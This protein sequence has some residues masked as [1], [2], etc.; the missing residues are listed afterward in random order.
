MKKVMLLLANGFEMYEAAV[1][2]DVFGWNNDEIAEDKVELITVGLRDRIKCTW[3]FTVIPEKLI[4]EVNIDE[5]DALAI[6]G[7]FEEAGFYEDAYSK[8]FL[9][10]IKDFNDQGKIISSVCVAALPVAKSGALNGRKGITF[11]LNEGYR[12][13]QLQ[14]FGVELSDTLFT[15]DDNIVTCSGPGNAMQVALNL[16]ERLT[17]KENMEK[18]KFAMGF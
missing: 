6:P 3:N 9:Q 8:T 14:E 7:G 16:L 10:L 11:H 13:K 1:F 12:T 4:S 18:V 17:S 15:E 5:Y 2:T